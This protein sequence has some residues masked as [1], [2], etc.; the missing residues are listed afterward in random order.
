[1]SLTGETTILVQIMKKVNFLIFLFFMGMSAV[2]SAKDGYKIKVHL[3]N[4]KDTMLYLVHYFAEPLP[5]I[6]KADSARINKKGEATLFR[7]DSILGGIY[8]ILPSE[9][10]SYFEFLMTN[11]TDM[12]ISADMKDLPYSVS[13][14]GSDE[15]SKFY[16]YVHFLKSFGEKQEAFKKEMS[17][18][19]TARDTQAIR[20]K[21]SAVTKD[22][23]LYRNNYE[24]KYPNTLL[25]NIFNAL[26]VPVVPPGDHFL[27]DGTKDTLYS[28]YYYK[29][30]FW[31]K[32]NFKDDR[33]IHAPI[34]H[35]KLDEYF[36]KVTYPYEDSVIK[37]ADLLLARIPKR[38]ELFKYALYWITY[39]AQ[40]S[41]IM[42]MDRVFVHMVMN[43]H[44][45][46][47]AFWLDSDQ[48][49]KYY[50]EA[51][52]KSPNLIG[53]VAP[54]LQ[55]KDTADKVVKLSD[56]KSKYTLLV[57]WEPTCGHCMQEVP[58]IDSVYQASLKAKGVKIIGIKTD[59]PPET[60]KSF[61]RKHKLYD[62]INLY[63]PENTSNF[64]GK[65]DVRSTP[66]LYLL[67]ENKIIIGKRLDYSNIETV[68]DIT[69]R[70]KADKSSI[71]K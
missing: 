27:P 55:L 67:D 64:R 50:E 71:K 34:F 13:F 21:A 58:R 51:L 33:L 17:Q 66:I 28:Y 54:E 48:L 70:K 42:G 14:V 11:G 8:M 69:E 60:W 22:L 6:Y 43:Y 44:M 52:K 15:N 56:I 19:K 40:T 46:G 47:D 10:N 31:D 38:T 61:I 39:N 37:E 5:K 20:D 4:N 2:V 26:E 36:N 65:Y 12:T 16:E 7:K 18:A 53:Q 68:I 45:K 29:N 24:K 25:A 9:R 30:H 57:F 41:K 23:T 1:M 49:T 63:D 32:F 35:A 3:K 62:W 59:D